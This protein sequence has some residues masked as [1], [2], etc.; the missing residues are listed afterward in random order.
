M[1]GAR[2]DLR[3]GLSRAAGLWLVVLAV[4]I[5]AGLWLVAV[6]A[7]ACRGVVRGARP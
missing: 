7:R 4:W 6:L 2:S 3:A 5:G 1:R